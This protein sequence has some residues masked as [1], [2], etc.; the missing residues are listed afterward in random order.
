MAKQIVIIYAGVNGHLDDIPTEK[1]I[2]FEAELHE[3]LD[4]TGADLLRLINK[5]KEM[6]DEVKAAADK[7][8]EEFKR[9]FKG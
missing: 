2:Q 3:A 7:F 1:V 5:R 4:A 9:T 8:L 6:D